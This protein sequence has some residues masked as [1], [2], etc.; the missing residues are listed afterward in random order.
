MLDTHL[1]FSAHADYQKPKHQDKMSLLGRVRNCVEDR[2]SLMHYKA[3]ILLLFDYCDYVN[4]CLY[5][6]DSYTLHSVKCDIYPVHIVCSALCILSMNRIYPINYNLKKWIHM[7]IFRCIFQVIQQA[8][9]NTCCIV[10]TLL[11][12]S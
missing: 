12:P 11:I 2:T 5:Q 1:H 10:I 9:G 4:H 8:H 7:Q 6:N 3:L